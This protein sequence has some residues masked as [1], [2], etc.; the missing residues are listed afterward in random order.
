MMMLLMGIGYDDND[1]DINL[2]LFTDWDRTILRPLILDLLIVVIVDILD[3]IIIMLVS[4]VFI[5]IICARFTFAPDT[6]SNNLKVNIC[7]ISSKL[8]LT[9]FAFISFSFSSSAV[10]S[11]A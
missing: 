7:Q 5:L 11:C 8:L 3:I 2:S 6:P 1:D 10:I 4:V 9:S